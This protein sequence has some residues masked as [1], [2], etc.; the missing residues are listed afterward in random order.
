MIRYELSDSFVGQ[1]D[2]PD[3]GH[4]RAKVRWRAEE[5]PHYD[6]VDV[7]AHVVCYVLVRSPEIFDYRV[8]QTARGIDVEALAAVPV[9][10]D[11]LPEHLVEALAAGLH[12]PAVSVRIVDH[13]EWIP[14]TGKAQTLPAT[15]VT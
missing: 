6:G 15:A 9:N 8:R 3:H 10:S 11:L 1:P 4:L 2:A 5:V 12:N 7:H 13:P 14:D